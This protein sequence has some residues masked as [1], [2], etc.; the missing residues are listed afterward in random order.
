MDL[1]NLDLKLDIETL[2]EKML[3]Y[4]QVEAP[5]YHHFS[6]GLYT[7][8]TH[9]PAGMLAVGKTHRYK[10]TNILLKGRISVIMGDDVTEFVAPCIFVSEAGVA[11]V[12][13]FHED[14]VWLNCHPTPETDI[15][16]IEM[17]VII[18]N[19]IK[20]IEEV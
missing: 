17:D 19:P 11:K 8:E 20:L 2:K 18:P 10:V 3:D 15:E 9:M 7:R 12:A 16:K 1:L 13:Y 4:P 5:V 14:T 6:D